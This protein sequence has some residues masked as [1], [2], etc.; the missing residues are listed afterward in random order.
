MRFLD[1]I[2]IR[3]EAGRGG[4]GAVSFRREKFVP[5]GGPDGGDGGRGGS[6]VLRATTQYNTLSHLN[7]KTLYRADHG[8][9]GMSG[10]K[11]G[12]DSSDIV[13]DVPLG[14]IVFDERGAEVADLT[15]DDERFVLAHGGDG[16]K[17]N[18]HFRSATRQA[19]DFAKPGFPGEEGTYRLELKLIAE[20]GL[21]GYPNVGKS[22]LIRQISS[23]KS[24]VGAYPFTTR[25]PHLAAIRRPYHRA[26]LIIA[27]LPGLIDGA[28]QGAGLGLQFLRHA[29]R[30]RCFV[31][32]LSA[33]F[34]LHARQKFEAINHELSSYNPELIR[35]PQLVVL[36]KCDLVDD[37]TLIDAIR[38]D[39]P[40]YPFF[41]ISAL[42]IEGLAPLVAAI[43]ELV[44]PIDD[45]RA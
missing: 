2:T 4:H 26:P 31:H 39:F 34:G 23:S 15:R 27:D 1:E 42:K 35:R 3:V 25:F 43:H 28:H 8:G 16:G 13:I 33:E 44:P 36:N 11:S 21:V 41:V 45:D 12:S 9:N 29:E 14:T 32:V 5:K 6:V 22:T 24:K 17:G 30:T 7:H 18:W 19:P 37:Q 38:R 40:D 10:R 20:V